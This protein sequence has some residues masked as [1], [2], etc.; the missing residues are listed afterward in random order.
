MLIDGGG[1]SKSTFDIGE[2][3]VAPVLLKRKIKNL[4][5]VVLTHPHPDHL[6]GLV[7][8]VRDFKVNEVWTNGEHTASET[9]KELEDIIAEKGIRKLLVSSA[10]TNRKMEEV[11]IEVLHPPPSAV[12]KRDKP[13]HILINNHSLVMRLV[14]KNVSILFTGDIC[15]AAESDLLK[16]S[17][18][19]KSTMLKVPHYGSKTSS[20]IPF[21][22]A[23]DPSIAI[24]SVG[25]N[26]I[27]RLPSLAVIKR[28]QDQRCKLLR[29]DR[30]GA[31]S[32]ETDGAAITIETYLK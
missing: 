1:F 7:S 8:L 28:Y 2:K 16:N 11:I 4:D 9:F 13:S 26:N 22:K 20:S 5:I 25:Y 10:Q 23:V 3:V 6:N 18:A 24:L 15:E 14:H 32:I 29:T 19:L 31:I 17:S 30:D 21:L 27:F 12:Y